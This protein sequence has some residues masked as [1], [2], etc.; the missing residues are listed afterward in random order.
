[1]VFSKI[2]QSQLD[3]FVLGTF[4]RTIPAGSDASFQAFS[5]AS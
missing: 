3:I 1:M 4:L 2:T 5:A